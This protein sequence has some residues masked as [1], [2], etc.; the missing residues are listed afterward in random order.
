[1][2][3][4]MLLWFSV[5]VG[6]QNGGTGDLTNYFELP[7]VTAEIE[8]HAENEWLDLYG[9]Y[10]NGMYHNE[11][12]SFNPAQDSFSVGARITLDC[13][14]IEYQHTCLHPVSWNPEHGLTEFGAV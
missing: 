6:L 10:Y 11:G 12:L 4:G 14:S 3:L 1:M 13:F 9:I 7:P 8:I 2:I 5:G